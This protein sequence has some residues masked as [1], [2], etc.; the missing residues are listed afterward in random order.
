VNLAAMTQADRVLYLGAT[1]HLQ[2]EVHYHV[3]LRSNR[4]CTEDIT[5]RLSDTLGILASAPVMSSCHNACDGALLSVF[6]R[7]FEDLAIKQKICPCDPSDI[8][9]SRV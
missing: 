5:S 7:L 6:A 3:L 9:D 4:L 2:S 1:R 8:M